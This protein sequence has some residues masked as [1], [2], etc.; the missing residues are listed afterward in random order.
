MFCTALKEI[1]DVSFQ[2]EVLEA[3]GAVLV[4]YKDASCE[5]PAH[6]EYFAHRYSGRLTI[7]T[8]DIDENP[9]IAARYGVREVPV[10][11]LFKDKRRFS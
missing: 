10:V 7:V 4:Y 11:M 9:A 8:L 5:P 6:F 3:E 2:A 1:N